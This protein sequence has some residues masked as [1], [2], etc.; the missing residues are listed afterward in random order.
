MA[1]DDKSMERQV[2]GLIPPSSEGVLAS[3]SQLSSTVRKPSSTSVPGQI[4]RPMCYAC[5][6]YE[7]ELA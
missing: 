4:C 3:E 7:V 2:N 6:L 1:A 5:N